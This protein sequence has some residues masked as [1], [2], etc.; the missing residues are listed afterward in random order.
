M[1][2]SSSITEQEQRHEPRLR[3]LKS[4][5]I[6][7]ENGSPP[8]HCTI[9]Q[10]SVDGARIETDHVF[11][12]DDHVGLY[13]MTENITIVARVVWQSDRIAGLAFDRPVPWLAAHTQT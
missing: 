6:Q 1:G 2:W 8:A 5:R 10:L 3:A 4:A 11:R 9:R 13:F 12:I 7:F